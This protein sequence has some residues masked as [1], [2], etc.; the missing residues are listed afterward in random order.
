MADLGNGP[1]ATCGREHIPG[2]WT[3]RHPYVARVRVEP[4]PKAE[5][6]DL[7]GDQGPL[8]LRARCHLTAPLAVSLEGETLIVR[9]YVP[10]CGREVVRFEVVRPR[11]T[12]EPSR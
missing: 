11:V 3:P 6:C 1:C 12:E 7:C 4:V 8:L 10:N 9:C 2:V 5:G